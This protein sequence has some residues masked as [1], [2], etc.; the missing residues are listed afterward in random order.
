MVQYEGTLTLYFYVK[1]SKLGKE[2]N[3]SELHK[4]P[5]ATSVIQ[6]VKKIMTTLL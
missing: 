1:V 3:L 2:G 6:Y 4:E 5:W